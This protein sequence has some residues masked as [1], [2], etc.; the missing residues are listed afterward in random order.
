MGVTGTPG[1]PL[2]T[3]LNVLLPYFSLVHLRSSHM[4]L[5][6]AYFYRNPVEEHF[7]YL[8]LSQLRPQAKPP[9]FEFPCRRGLWVN[10]MENDPLA[11]C[12]KTAD[13]CEKSYC[14]CNIQCGFLGRLIG[15]LK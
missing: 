11:S 4:R 15:E 9:L 12:V 3:S 7:F 1:P 14:S 6:G 13:N 10:T 5:L 8:A 2:A